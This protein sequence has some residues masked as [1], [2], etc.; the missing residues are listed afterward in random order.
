M[1]TIHN[2]SFELSILQIRHHQ[3]HMNSS[4][5]KSDKAFCR[6]T[7]D[8]Q[9]YHN[10]CCRNVPKQARQGFLPAFLWDTLHTHAMNLPALVTAQFFFTKKEHQKAEPSF[11]FL[12]FHKEHQKH[13]MP[14]FIMST[15][16]HCP[17]S[18]CAPQNTALFHVH[19]KTLPCF[20]V[21]TTK[22]CPVL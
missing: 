4:I 1:M 18:W 21:C 9:Q 10:G 22:H 20:M 14:C 15:T 8:H 19:H 7:F 6:H 12:F 11:F 17:V 2:Y 3:T 5:P 16:K 13:C